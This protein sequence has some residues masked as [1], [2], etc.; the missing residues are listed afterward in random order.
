MGS[1]GEVMVL[2]RVFLLEKEGEYSGLRQALEIEKVAFE[3]GLGNEGLTVS[4]EYFDFSGKNCILVGIAASKKAFDSFG[5]RSEIFSNTKK[6][7]LL[8]EGFVSKKD[9]ELFAKHGFEKIDLPVKQFLKVYSPDLEVAAWFETSEGRFPAVV[10]KGNATLVLFDLDRIF[11]GIL[12]EKFFVRS[13]SKENRIIRVVFAELYR[14]YRM[15]PLSVRKTMLKGLFYSNKKRS[16]DKFPID[17]TSHILLC[18][19]LNLLRR[20]TPLV[21][22]NR[23]PGGHQSALLIT[24]DIEPTE[25]AYKEGL[26][27]ML[28]AIGDGKTTVNLV[29]QFAERYLQGSSLFSRTNVEYAS[30]GLKHDMFFDQISEKEREERV[31]KSLEIIHRL[32]GKPV[33]GY[34]SSMLSKPK[35]FNE[36]I[37][38]MG[39]KYDMSYID[40]DFEEPKHGNG[41]FFCLPYFLSSDGK[42]SKV[43]EFPTSAP[44]CISPIYMGFTKEETF[45]L[46]DKKIEYIYEIGGLYVPIVHA[47]AYGKDDEELR[48]ELL[49]R[50]LAKVGGLKFWRITGS[51]LRDWWVKRDGISISLNNHG[52]AIENKN[53]VTVGRVEIVVEMPIKLKE[54]YGRCEIRDENGDTIVKINRL[55]PRETL[56]IGDRP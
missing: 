14:V 56:V 7:Q 44:D 4:S 29:G 55:K 8:T 32:S 21:R 52:I 24:H 2:K 33:N 35:G 26:P 25:Y 23:W 50:I 27:A 10:K 1:W 19:F 46:F 5:I 13:A 43:V 11:S 3:T 31:A 54:S 6:L 16:T 38:R 37:E 40:V 22:I 42:K 39:V 41:I 17:A 47:G 53:D 18:G 45:A 30:H 36:L 48:E 34:R 51:E 9:S 49:K 20:Y 28:T 12:N 15:L